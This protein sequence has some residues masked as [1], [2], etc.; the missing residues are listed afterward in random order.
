MKKH[1]MYFVVIMAVMFMVTLA[2]SGSGGGGG[3]ATARPTRERIE[4]TPRV[5]PNDFEL[6]DLDRTPV[7]TIPVVDD[8]QAI[9][10]IE[11]FAAE[12]LGLGIQGLKA[13][14]L[15]GQFNLPPII[16][17]EVN[18]AIQAAGATYYGFWPEGIAS[19]SFGDANISGNFTADVQDGTL[20]TFVVR[21]KSSFPGDSSSALVLV[22]DVFPELR[23]YDFET[24]PTQGNA[25]S[26]TS[27]QENRVYIEA[28]NAMLA[29]TVFLAGVTPD[30][31]PE[32]SIVYV[33]MASGALATPFSK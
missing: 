29:G 19:L 33:V 5:D 13:G 16:Q 24:Q 23:N 7:I 21:A 10:A 18:A 3:A 20:G 28:W 25:Y 30:I 1:K 8:D 6:P 2:C 15:Q 14:G 4:R 32:N 9:E 11:T 27:L 17:D 26:F 22:R 12:A 31:N